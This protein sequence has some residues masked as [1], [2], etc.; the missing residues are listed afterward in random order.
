MRGRFQRRWRCQPSFALS[1]P[2]SGRGEPRPRVGIA[3]QTDK[4]GREGSRVSSSAR[5]TWQSLLIYPADCRSSC[6]YGA[7]HEA[8]RS[9]RLF[10]TRWEC[11]FS[12]MPDWSKSSAEEVCADC[13][14][15][16][17]RVVYCSSDLLYYSAK[18]ATRSWQ[19]NR[20][21]KCSA[22]KCIS[23]ATKFRNTL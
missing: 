23:N 2:V 5:I 3:E 17:S 10:N 6:W 21:L 9:N 22:L 12:P 13:T 15:D 7:R 20:V 8:R 16:I 14:C 1:R 19:N 18:N 11:Q 4:L